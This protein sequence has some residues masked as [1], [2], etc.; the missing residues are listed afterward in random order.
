[1]EEGT[2]V[3]RLT[4]EVTE[5]Q[6]LVPEG[7]L[8][9]IMAEAEE[10]IGWGDSAPDSKSCLGISARCRNLKRTFITQVSLLAFIRLTRFGLGIRKLENAPNFDRTSA[11]RETNKL[12]A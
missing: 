9:S 11:S 10:A 8:R 2:E 5:V 12:N 3:V 7:T 6:L 1:M 4:V